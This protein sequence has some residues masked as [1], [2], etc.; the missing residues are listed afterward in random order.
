MKT[1]TRT[2]L[3]FEL[4]ETGDALKAVRSLCDE[5]C[6]EQLTTVA[7]SRAAPRW[8]AAVANLAIARLELL[9][10]VV[11]GV[12]DPRLIASHFNKAIVPADE[13]E[14]IV[15]VPWSIKQRHQNARAELRRRR[16]RQTK[17][18]RHKR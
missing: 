4:S 9:R 1:T 14:E 3:A 16:R 7:E 2:S 10:D 13:S 18:R 17:T 8:C 6:N 5:L 12:E 15:L 11:Y